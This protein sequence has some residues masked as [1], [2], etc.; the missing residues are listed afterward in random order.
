MSK[1]KE[2]LGKNEARISSDDQKILQQMMME[3][4]KEAIKLAKS[5]G[6]KYGK[7]KLSDTMVEG[8]R[9]D[10][11]ASDGLVMATSKYLI[12]FSLNAEED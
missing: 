6:L 2:L 8:E 1:A 12:G 5:I 11:D 9:I 10:Y 4:D 7:G 3:F